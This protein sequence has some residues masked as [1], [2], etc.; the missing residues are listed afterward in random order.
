MLRLLIVS[1]AVLFSFNAMAE[2]ADIEAMDAAAR[3]AQGSS[4]MFKAQNPQEAMAR[5]EEEIR[6]R[7]A[8]EEHMR[9]EEEARRE[10]QMR[11][12][13]E[14]RRKALRPVNL[15]GNGLK[16][17]AEVNGEIITSR[18][19]QDRVN[20]FVATTQIP[21]NNQTKDMIIGKVLQSAVDEKIKLQE[22]L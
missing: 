12:M 6:R 13:E 11:Q 10:E 3:S 5:R 2:Q 21:V 22:L 1:A 16:I 19:M 20:A 9:R 14:E 15:F 7:Q 4:V 17:F 18:D 8:Y